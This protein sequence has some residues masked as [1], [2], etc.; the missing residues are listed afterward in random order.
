MSAKDSV[1]IQKST[2]L[3]LKHGLYPRE[4]MQPIEG[5]DPDFEYLVK[6]EP[7]PAPDYDSRYFVLNKIDAITTDTH[8]VYTWLN[9]FKTTHQVVKRDISEIQFHVKQAQKIAD[10]ALCNTEEQLSFTLKVQSALDRLQNGLSLTI[11]E[12]AIL[13]RSRALKVKLDKNQDNYNVLMA[14]IIDGTEPDLNAGWQS[15]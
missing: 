9:V 10:T 15:V 4:D 1:L 5:L 8:P 3:I 7:F 14:A 12:Q 6:Y 2:G 13:D 11:E